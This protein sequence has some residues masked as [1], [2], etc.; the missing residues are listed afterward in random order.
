MFDVGASLYG[1]ESQV[2]TFTIEVVRIPIRVVEFDPAIIV[3]TFLDSHTLKLN[4]LD[5]RTSDGIAGALIDVLWSDSTTVQDLPNGSYLI[6]FD[7]LNMHIG[8]YLLNVSLEKT[9]YVDG[10][11]SIPIEINPIVSELVYET[12]FSQYENETIQITVAFNDLSHGAAIDWG[13]L[14]IELDGSLYVMTYNDVTERYTLSIWLDSTIDP[15]IYNLT[16]NAEA[17]DCL[18]VNGTIQLEVLS[19]A[20]YVLNIESE[21]EVVAGNTLDITVIATEEGA[22]ATGLQ[23]NLYIVATVRDGGE[24]TYIEVVIT[25]SEGIATLN[26]EVPDDVSELSILAQ[27]DGSVSEWPAESTSILVEVSSA[28]PDIL[29]LLLDPLTLTIILG[30]ASIP[31]VAVSLR[32]RRRHSGSVKAAI[33]ETEDVSVDS[34]PTSQ[35]IGER[36]RNEIMSSEDGLTRAELSKRLGPSASKIGAMVRELLQ[37]DSGFNEVREGSRRVIRYRRLD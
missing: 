13:S 9:G 3:V 18:P 32:R 31:L 26:F 12:D 28:G 29:T 10:F 36:L 21:R 16:L 25:N 34:A 17:V 14:T 35:G 37:S 22:A 20:T 5:N 27:Y 7:T 24:R 30:G 23:I 19:K 2:S 8:S 1:H 11:V 6:Q 15:G 4:Y 33:E